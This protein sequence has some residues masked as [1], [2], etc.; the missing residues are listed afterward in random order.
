MTK[1]E[2]L[3]NY[4]EN[5]ERDKEI[6]E[7]RAKKYFKELE[8]RKK[9]LDNDINQLVEKRKK[10]IEEKEKS[11]KIKKDKKREDLIKDEKKVERERLKKNEEIM[12]KYKPFINI[13]NEKTKN[14]YLYVIYDKKFKD[15]YEKKIKNQLSQGKFKSSTVTS[16][17]LEEFLRQIEER[18]EQFKKK[19]E[20][21]NRKEKENNFKPSY[22]S[23]FNEKASEEYKNIRQKEENRKEEILALKQLKENYSSDIRKNKL[24]SVN[25]ELKKKRMDIILEIEN[26]KLLQ[27]KDTLLK[28]K[29]P[30]IEMLK[31]DDPKNQWMKDLYKVES[32]NDIYK[33]LNNSAI[34]EEKLIKRPKKIPTSLSAKIR[35]DNNEKERKER[36]EKEKKIKL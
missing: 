13:K 35:E 31:N 25:E 3:Q 2:K 4:R 15:T 5:F 12:L 27:I 34:I 36:K 6:I 30:I 28:K 33:N 7:A 10:E 17:E 18:K 29:K 32:I 16:A 21:E 9:R 22:I 11:E 8:K 26:P 14:D 20:I 1:R 24:P 19:K 23:Q